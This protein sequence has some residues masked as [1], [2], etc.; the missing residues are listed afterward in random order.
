MQ[1]TVESLQTSKTNVTI[2][3]NSL[4]NLGKA[5]NQQR[6]SVIVSQLAKNK[7]AA[8]VNTSSKEVA[9]HG[10]VIKQDN[11]YHITD[12]LVYPQIA[13][14][15]TVESNDDSYPAWLDSLDDETFNTIRMQGHS[16]VNMGVTPSSTDDTFYETLTQ[17][18]NDYYIFIILNKSGKL[19]INLYD[20]ENQ[21]VY[22]TS[23]I[24]ITY[25]GY[26]FNTWAEDEI[27]SNVKEHSYT[28]PKTYQTKELP[29]HSRYNIKDTNEMTTE[30]LY[31]DYI[32]NCYNKKGW[33]L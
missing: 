21:I 10:T 12:I 22:D 1:S 4:T 32:K 20:L 7:M 13:T 27:K 23:D 6:Q 29:K 11:A 15:A 8:L 19:W 33:K 2:S 26:N 28:P 24:D 16:H 5:T 30:E 9:W 25:E 17:H 31:E 3:F 14:S 18:I